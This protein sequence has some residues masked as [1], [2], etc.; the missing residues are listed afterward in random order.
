MFKNLIFIIL[1]LNFTFITFAEDNSQWL[2]KN[3]KGM[4]L[5]KEGNFNLSK[6]FY[7]EAIEEAKNLGLKAELSATLNN[8]G[9]L[10]IELLKIK[11][12]KLIIEESLRI[13]LEVYGVN[14]RYVAQSYNNLARAYESSEEYDEA[15]KLYIESVKVYEMLGE[16][17]NMLRART[18]NNLSIAQIKNG[19]LD[20]AE[21]NLLGSMA[22]S[23]KYGFDNSVFL[24]TVSNLASIYSS[25]GNYIESERLYKKLLNLNIYNENDNSIKLARI[26]NNIAVVLKKQCK[27]NEA[28]TYIE[29]S[30]NI[31]SNI[32]GID[33]LNYSSAFHNYG[34][35][36]KAL[37]K[38]DLAIENFIKSLSILENHKATQNEQYILQAYSLINIYIQLEKY[39]FINKVLDKINIK[40]KENNQKPISLEEIPSGI[41]ENCSSSKI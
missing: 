40:R 32:G 26:Y 2:L 37:G 28:L 15:I 1:F 22:I 13:R 30:I 7:L 27:Y 19:L 10:N 29:K 34:E 41:F 31:W 6:K 11:E 3:K 21:K 20:S 25:L 14:H 16:K 17:Y 36:N 35:L 33:V 18:L 24:T 5:Y 8:L 38:F 12:A 9:L 39:S 4:Q 23:K